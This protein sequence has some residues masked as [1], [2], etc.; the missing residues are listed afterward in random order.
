MY[1][2]MIPSLSQQSKAFEHATV[3]CVIIATIHT[4]NNVY[5]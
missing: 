3:I 4:Q 1:V 2:A 5:E